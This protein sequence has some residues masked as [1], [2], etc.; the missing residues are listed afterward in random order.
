MLFR[1]AL[2]LRSLLGFYPSDF[3]NGAFRKPE[4]TISSSRDTYGA[5]VGCRDGILIDGLFNETRKDHMSE[6]VAPTL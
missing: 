6:L 2:L 5:A 4:V 3:I 1:P